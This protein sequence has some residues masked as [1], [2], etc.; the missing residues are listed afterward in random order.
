[1]TRVSGIEIYNL[2][3]FFTRESS[4][5]KGRD[6]SRLLAVA[7]TEPRSMWQI[8]DNRGSVHDPLTG[9]AIRPRNGSIEILI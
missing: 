4:R 3:N 9:T 7:T 5:E 6:P 2:I 1:M 8:S